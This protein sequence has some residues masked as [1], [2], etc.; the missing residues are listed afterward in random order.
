MEQVK[1]CLCF[2]HLRRYFVESIPL[3]SKGKEIPSSKG[4]EGKS[5]IDFL[6]EFEKKIKNLP[7]GENKVQCQVG[8]KA[9]L[10]AFSR[11]CNK[12]VIPTRK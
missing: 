4:T 11:R 5:Y 12:V 3:D 1:R 9:I 6:F 7:F 8:A 10:D 2:S